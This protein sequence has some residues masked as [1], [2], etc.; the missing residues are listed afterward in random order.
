MRLLFVTSTRIGDAV[1]STA[2]LN[3][4]ILRNPG[5]KVTVACGSAAAGVFASVPNL[6]KIIVVHKKPYG[7]HWFDLW[8]QTAPYKWD[9]AIDLRRSA[10]P[11]FLFAKK[12]IINKKAD[13]TIHRVQD[14]ANLIGN[15]AA[16]SPTVW[17]GAEHRRAAQSFV[18]NL[19]KKPVLCLAPTAN[20]GGKMWPPDRFV[21]LVKKLTSDTGILP[22]ADI[23]VF[24]AEHERIQAQPVLDGLSGHNVID[25]IGKPDLLTCGSIFEQS[26]LY[27]G[28]DSGLMHLAAASGANV[29]GLFGPSPARNYAPWP[30]PPGQVDFVQTKK[31]Y[32]QIVGDP[33]FDHRKQDS[34]MTTLTVEMAESCANNLWRKIQ[35][36]KAA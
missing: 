13:E 12:R 6:E 10:L 8:R 30:T 36:K 16:I 24:G 5:I 34:L 26:S 27:I 32:E 17:I 29:M 28:N 25:L 14:L 23:A 22:G 1:L 19:G 33:T 9:I 18:P 11:Y 7:M 35:H 20:W 4:Y 2:L 21:D 15:G 31:T 3:Y